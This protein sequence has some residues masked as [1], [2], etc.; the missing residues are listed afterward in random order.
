M[1]R[2]TPAK[3]VRIQYTHRQFVPE[4]WMK[5]ETIGPIEG[6]T[7][8]ARAKRLIA[9]PRLSPS[10]IS[11]RRAPE[12][13]NGAAA[14]VPPKNLKTKMDAVFLLSAQPTWKHV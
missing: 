11:A 14:K 5:P 13:V 1:A 2:Q 9:R 6:P 4:T 12:F 8:G 7:K 10:Q 3:M